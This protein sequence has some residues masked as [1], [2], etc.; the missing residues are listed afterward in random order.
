M[1][2]RLQ[3]I[4]NFLRVK[5][6][7][8]LF[9]LFNPEMEL[10]VNVAQDGGQR[11]QGEYA[12]KQWLAWSDGA[13]TW[14]SFRIPF[15]ANTEPEYTDKEIKY[16]LAAHAEGIGMTGWNWVKKSSHWL[17]YDFDAITGHS[18][19]HAKKLSDQE[20]LNIR[21]TLSRIPWV[22]LRASTSG[23]GLHMYVHID[24]S[25]REDASI[26]TNNHHEH[27]ALGRAILSM[28][29]ALCTYDFNTKVDVAG[30][31][32][33]VW[34]RKMLGTNGLQLLKDKTAYLQLKDIPQNWRDHLTVVRGASKKVGTG[35]INKS[36]DSDFDAA[37]DALTTQQSYT[38]LDREHRRV[39]DYLQTNGAM[40]WWDSDHNMLICHTYDLKMAH[41]ALG[42]KG[43]FDTISSGAEHGSDI[44]CYGCPLPKGA[45]VIR[46]YGRG[47]QEAPSWQQDGTNWTKCILN[48][49]VEFEV[50]MR[51][52]KGI[53]LEKGGFQFDSAEK[54]AEALKLLGCV[55]EVHPT[56]LR[57]ETIIRT[58][59]DEGKVVVGVL[60]SKEDRR[61]D[62]PASVLEKGYWK[63]ICTI[64]V[65]V[66][67]TGDRDLQYDDV[68]RHLVNAGS[69]DCGWVIKSQNGWNMEP[70]AHARAALGNL[71]YNTRET[72]D[73][74]G[75]NVFKPWKLV[76]QPFQPE[77]IGDRTWNRDAAQL[78]F[79][80]S[81]EPADHPTWASVLEH[82][83]QGLDEA[84]LKN[85]WCIANGI[86]KGSEYL[87]CWI[88][89]II[90]EPL[91]ALPYLFFYSNEQDTGKSTFHESLALL[92]TKGVINANAAI[93]SQGG[94]NAEIENAVVCYIEEID[95]KKNASAYGRIKEWV[96]AINLMVHKKGTT[97][98]M[99]KN[100][101]H[102]CQSANDAGAVPVFPGDSRI[103]MI[104]VKPF[105]PDEVKL[106]KKELQRLLEKEAPDFL[107][108]LLALE[109][110]PHNDRLNLPIIDT[111]DKRLAEESNMDEIE[112]FIK[113]VCFIRSGHVILLSEAYDRFIEWLPANRA[114]EYSKIKFG[115]G[116][117]KPIVKGRLTR[118]PNVHIGNVT[119]DPDAQNL[120]PLALSDGFLRC[121]V[122][123]PS[124]TVSE[125]EKT[126]SPDLSP[127][128]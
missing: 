91:Q 62:M 36:A 95:L 9:V 127:S 63:Q 110:P 45:W 11:V 70:L 59:K 120:A 41:K 3:A 54:A 5:T 82:C 47:T 44:N 40:W 4:E 42:L 19:K 112:T 21:E 66:K 55:F 56:L 99:V 35:T 114:H 71:E 16:D 46:R 103:T 39:V 125:P 85:E 124:G 57:R 14:K 32:M 122:S 101:T 96:T 29:C 98:Y 6:H 94:F 17:A 22:Q 119:F 20:L 106:S 93:T 74:I 37:F 10:Q 117:P 61:D 75:D 104:K 121:V 80:P 86:V 1:P 25:A 34:H 18:D 8:D 7:P 69:E 92:F 89:S 64:N 2:T 109:L 15:K 107:A 53:E 77:Y 102:W 113:D 128:S 100:C 115:K 97:P 83:G 48:R 38:K 28:L 88:A 51:L 26:R 118:D 65:P 76:N 105:G 90:K 111:E 68:V 84:V 73:I 27:A 67:L 49:D 12:G 60:A 126:P 58:H 23:K 33:W 72:S 108:S 87:K 50:A 123:S 30:G 79:I 52:N 24:P 81:P 78:R 116:L 31:N 43:I 13:T